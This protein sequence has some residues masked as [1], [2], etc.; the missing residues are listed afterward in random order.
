MTPIWSEMM[1]N[2]MTEGAEAVAN[3]RIS[4]ATMPRPMN[5]PAMS[6][7]PKS[8]AR[9][10]S[11]RNATYVVHQIAQLSL[12]GPSSSVARPIGK[13]GQDISLYSGMSVHDIAGSVW[14]SQHLHSLNAKVEGFMDLPFDWDGD[15][16]IAPSRKAGAAASEFLAGLAV[17]NMPNECYAVGDGEIVFQ[18]RRNGSFIEVAFNGSTI[19][20]YAKLRNEKIEFSDDKFSGFTTIDH[21]LIAAI[22]MMG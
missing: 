7:Y 21:R 13:L 1:N 8:F 10:G 16:G 4:M 20:W 2:V 9:R 3:D 17:S 19:S 15:N 12:F 22:R 6:G 14:Y 11:L 5:L 18:W